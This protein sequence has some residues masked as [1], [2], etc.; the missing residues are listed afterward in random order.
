MAVRKKRIV[1][2]DDSA[3]IVRMLEVLLGSNYE[4]RGFTKADRALAFLE[5]QEADL[6]ILDIDMP[7]MN[8]I[9]VLDRIRANPESAM[10][11]IM[12]TSN[13]DKGHVLE[14]F[15]HGA[16]DYALKPIDEEAFIQKINK[17]LYMKKR[18]DVKEK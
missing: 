1:A 13:N 11:I 15:K 4:F 8:G 2:L 17:L 12:L 6:L 16:N 7:E 14:C 3:I 9:E 18:K 5:V 10:P